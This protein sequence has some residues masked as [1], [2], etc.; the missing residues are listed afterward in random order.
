MARQHG[1]KRNRRPHDAKARSSDGWCGS[2]CWDVC[3]VESEPDDLC[4]D[5]ESWL[6]AGRPVGSDHQSGLQRGG[7]AS[8]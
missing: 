5:G 8:S 3:G 4:A 1:A 6:Q 2:E 7:S